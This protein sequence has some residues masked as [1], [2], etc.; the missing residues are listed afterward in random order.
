M[1]K[2]MGKVA[3]LPHTLVATSTSRSPFPIPLHSYL[4]AGGHPWV[5]S[6]GLEKPVPK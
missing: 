6:D 1:P 2:G 5:F 4:D 3:G